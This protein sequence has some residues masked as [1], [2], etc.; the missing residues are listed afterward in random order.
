ME[1]RVEEPLQ[2]NGSCQKAFLEVR[3]V[4][5]IRAKPGFRPFQWRSTLPEPRYLVQTITEQV[6]AFGLTNTHTSFPS[7]CFWVGRRVLSVPLLPQKGQLTFSSST[8]WF[9]ALKI[10]V[11][12]YTNFHGFLGQGTCG[13][14]PA[15][16]DIP[17]ALADYN[18]ENFDTFDYVTGAGT[19][20]YTVKAVPSGPEVADHNNGVIYVGWS[21]D[22]LISSTC[23]GSALY[24]PDPTPGY[25]V[26]SYVP[27]ACPLDPPMT[28]D[29]LGGL[30]LD[31]LVQYTE[32]RSATSR[33]ITNGPPTWA[34]CRQIQVL[35]Q[36][37]TTGNLE[38]AVREDLD[39][40]LPGWGTHASLRTCPNLMGPSTDRLCASRNLATDELSMSG[41]RMD[42]RMRIPQSDSGLDYYVSYVLEYR[43]DTS[44]TRSQTS[45]EIYRGTGGTLFTATHTN[46][47]PAGN[48]RVCLVGLRIA[49]RPRPIAGSY[50]HPSS[51]PGNASP[52]SS[53]ANPRGNDLSPPPG[54]INHRNQPGPYLP[55]LGEFEVGSKKPGLRISLGMSRDGQSAG[56]LLWTEEQEAAPG[57]PDFAG[58]IELQGASAPE[59]TMATDEQDRLMQIRAPQALVLNSFSL[60]SCHI[61]VFDQE[62]LESFTGEEEPL[63]TYSIKRLTAKSSASTY[64]ILE[65][66]PGS[67]IT[68]IWIRRQTNAW[69]CMDGNGLRGRSW[70]RTTLPGSPDSNGRVPFPTIRTRLEIFQPGSGINLSTVEE[71]HAALPWGNSLLSRRIDP[72]GLNLVTTNSY[73]DQGQLD[74]HLH[75]DGNWQRYAY[76][77]A[78]RVTTNF[79]AFTYGPPTV[80]PALCRMTVYG[81]GNLTSLRET[82]PGNP[83][84]RVTYI[85]GIETA[86]EY[87]LFLSNQTV[88]YEMD[89]AA[90]AWA[91]DRG[92]AITNTF[93][94]QDSGKGPLMWTRHSNQT[95]DVHF[96]QTNQEQRIHIILSGM[97]DPTQPTNILSGTRTTTV[98]GDFGLVQSIRV[99]D[100]ESGAI[101]SMIENTHDTRGRLIEERHA[102]GSRSMF[103]YG[104]CCRIT[105]EVDRDGI[106]AEFQYDALG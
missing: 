98:T 65:Q 105:R 54:P 60:D 94:P 87:S 106:S 12:Y 80:N 56:W 82:Q 58:R 34:P 84:T 93:Y 61:R 15:E 45:P 85:Q 10:F 8:A 67:I 32:T 40:N 26:N 29:F 102:D 53:G 16:N 23:T 72:D 6:D 38:Q 90:T 2:V 36:E 86:R 88:R 95:R 63:V 70:S 77:E 7:Y 41:Q 47:P 74:T 18:F 83:R 3:T 27:D 64:R 24:R 14:F 25:Q 92:R 62:K 50:N 39:N 37:Y 104:E 20:S 78:G 9:D 68:N 66:R 100:I 101:L 43:T 76:D 79:S 31:G 99:E 35:S 44:T 30:I 11:G 51:F 75:W 103:E 17:A 97:E 57:D 46:L 71:I 91:P 49:A 96:Y 81:Y 22:P 13:V 4:D 69:T 48:G 33:W 19:H 5:T 1:P 55:G 73:N 28:N 21:T 89:R 52:L 42:Y 59:T